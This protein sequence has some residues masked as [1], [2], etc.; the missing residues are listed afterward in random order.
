MKF[1]ILVYLILFCF[2]ADAQP[3]ECLIIDSATHAPV[4]F[5][6]I[7]IKNKPMAFYAN[8]GGKFALEDLNTTDTLQLSCIGYKSIELTVKNIVP[9]YE[10]QLSPVTIILDEIIIKG[11]A[12]I[13]IK[14]IPFVSTKSTY[15]SM[16]SIAM[17][18]SI[19]IILP[20]DS[21]LTQVKIAIKKTEDDNPIR[22]HIYEDDGFGKPGE[23]ILNRN[24]IIAKNE[25]KGGELVVDISAQNI[26]T[27]TNSIFVGIEWL[28]LKKEI[29]KPTG[30]KLKMT[31]D[32]IDAKTYTRTL[33]YKNWSLLGAGTMPLSKNPPNMLVSVSYQ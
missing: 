8:E 16:A 3:K 33:L 30:P 21:K 5:A 19:K 17:E 28:G 26:I 22:L 9:P 2:N 32:V 6:T 31:T 23:E 13:P 29:K 4:A 11:Y 27:H 10:I 20:K 12:N 18:N 1:Y 7:K 14:N 15:V 24:T 25:I